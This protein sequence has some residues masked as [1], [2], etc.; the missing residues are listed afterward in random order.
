MMKSYAISI[1]VIFL[2]L[3]LMGGG[4]YMVRVG[5][6]ATLDYKKLYDG[7][8]LSAM[9]NGVPVQV[10]GSDGKP[11]GNCRYSFTYSY[12]NGTSTAIST[13]HCGLTILAGADIVYMTKAPGKCARIKDLQTVFITNNAMDDDSASF[14]KCLSSIEKLKQYMWGFGITIVIIGFIVALYGAFMIFDAMNAK[15][16]VAVHPACAVAESTEHMVVVLVPMWAPP[17]GAII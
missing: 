6:Q 9:L 13:R 4:G 5:K 15:N 10:I 8:A 17:V 11:T 1:G 3:A 2:G 12:P 16:N 14:N 7:K